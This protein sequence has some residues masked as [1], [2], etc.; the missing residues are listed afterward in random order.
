MEVQSVKMAYSYENP[1]YNMA[2]VRDNSMFFGRRHVLRR[3]YAAVAN[4]QSFSLV[5]SLH[6][7]K[8]SVLQYAC[9]EEIQRTFEYDLTHHIFVFVDLREYFQKS[10]IDFFEA[11]S[12][13][14]RVRYP[15]KLDLAPDAEHGEDEFS[16][17]LG[18][19][20]EQGFHVVLLM[21]AFDNITRNQQFSPDFFTFLRALATV[22]KV[23]YVTASIAPLYDVCHYAIKSSPFFNIF[24]NYQLGPLTTEEAHE[25]ITVPARRA[26][27]TFSEQETHWLLTQ[28]GR[29]PFFIQRACHA[30]FEIRSAEHASTVDFKAVSLEMYKDLLPHFDYTWRQ[31]SESQQ[32][33]LKYEIQS[34]TTQSADLPELLESA[35]FRRFVRSHA[36]LHTFQLD[37]ASVEKALNKINDNRILAECE[38]KHLQVVSMRLNR[39]VTQ[40]TPNDWSRVIREV[41]IEAFERMRSN[42]VRR[43]GAPEWKLYNILYYRHFK[44][45]LNHEQIAARVEC[46][47]RQY[48]RERKKAIDMLCN[49]LLEM[50]AIATLSDEDAR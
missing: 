47:L 18:Q 38:L 30:L 45:H 24:L 19:I 46:S 48:F 40:P 37:S 43:D 1:Y 42:G 26:G 44:N 4:K 31:L 50:E 11:V 5:G 25:L 23:S 20:G 6:I 13:Q 17:L 29:H 3:L 9:R 14:I 33:T 2:T 7:G 35:L 34:Q 12:K 41:L 8:S 21:D 39:A 22:G 32:D 28:A 16:N 49:E 27:I 15:G 10:H 36:H